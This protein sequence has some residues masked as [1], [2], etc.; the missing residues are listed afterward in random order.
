M[1]FKQVTPSLEVSGSCSWNGLSG[2]V[3][4]VH[5]RL[6]MW[7]HVH[8]CANCNYCC[9][10]PK[11]YE[12]VSGFSPSFLFPNISPW[13]VMTNG[14]FST[15][16]LLLVWTEARSREEEGAER[17]EKGPSVGDV[18]SFFFTCEVCVIS[19]VLLISWWCDVFFFLFFF[20]FP[21]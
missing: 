14:L 11:S 12:G 19:E 1:G 20:F 9:L 21:K 8:A 15:S 17:R 3:W 7:K 10:L 5:T 18:S 13:P 6:G 4:L 2:F 16:S